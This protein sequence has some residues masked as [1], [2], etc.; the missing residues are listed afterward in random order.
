MQFFDKWSDGGDRAHSVTAGT[1]AVT[2]TASFKTKYSLNA[3]PYPST[4][5]K[6]SLSPD[7]TDAFFDA[8][9][10][11]QVTGV[12]ATGYKFSGYTLDMTGSANGQSIT[13]NDYNQ[14]AGIFARPGTIQQFSVMN[15]ATLQ[16]AYLAPG[17]AVTIYSPEFGPDPGVDAAESDNG[18]IASTLSDTRVLVNG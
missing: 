13:V 4:G 5:G 3:F 2:Y 11:V 12:P 14:V 16:P 15:A 17:G 9:A 7:S 10:T 8:G 18:K 6:I 1:D